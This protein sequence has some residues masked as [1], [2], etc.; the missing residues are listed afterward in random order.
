MKRIALLGSTG[1]IGTQ[2]LDLVFHHPEEF[3]IVSLACGSNIELV[4]KQ[5]LRFRPELISVGTEEGAKELK[6]LLENAEAA[7]GPYK[8]EIVYG[9]AGL[10]EAA[11]V[12][13]D[14]VVNALVG[15]IGLEPTLLALRAGRDI[16]LAN[17]ETLVTGG[18]LVTESA[19]LSGSHILPVDSE[20]SAIFQCIQSQS[21]DV[22]APLT[23]DY[24]GRETR[25][26]ILTASGGPFRGLTLKELNRVR[27]ADA[28][29]HPNWSMGNKVT[30]DSATMMNKGLEVIEA[31][32]LFNVTPEKIEVVVHRESVI[33]SA[34]EFEDGAVVAQLGT[35]D[36]KVP[37]AYALS[38]PDRMETG[39]KRLNLFDYGTLH[40]E[41]PDL[42]T[43]RCL[44]LALDAFNAGGTY[45]VILNA[46]NE[47]LV[48]RF[49]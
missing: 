8:P 13:A 39:V 48:A 31:C 30:I 1:S 44:K 2:T 32:H 28:L 21:A 35:P 43:F 36:M 23:P 15:M 42:E 26:I 18:T 33:H 14:L 49:L 29:K 38:Y 9:R 22:M 45:P 37:I 20:H 17:K 46:A 19:L 41:R 3:E 12:R 5:A 24:T 25:R 16:A 34:V 47:V 10:A 40:F 11:L 4:A 6:T 7:N 27:A